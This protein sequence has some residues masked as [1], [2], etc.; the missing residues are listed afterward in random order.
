MSKFDFFC[1]ISIIVM[2][3]LFIFCIPMVHDSIQMFLNLF[4]FDMTLTQKCD[5]EKREM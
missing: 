2:F 4:E 5:L 1:D 3:I